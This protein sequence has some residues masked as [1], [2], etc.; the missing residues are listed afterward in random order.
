MYPEGARLG[1]NTRSKHGAV[2]RDGA[3]ACRVSH[4]W[5]MSGTELH[6]TAGGVMSVQPPKSVK[7]VK[8]VWLAYPV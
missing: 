6:S 7:L 5:L 4:Q 8:V 1:Q 2:L 3:F